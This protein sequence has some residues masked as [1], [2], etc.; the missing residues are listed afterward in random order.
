MNA[1]GKDQRDLFTA[2]EVVKW[3]ERFLQK[4]GYEL[5]ATCNRIQPKP[6]FHGKRQTENTHYEIM[7]TACQNIQDA[8]NGL[9]K[10]K[11]VKAITTT[12]AD[13]VLAFPPLSEYSMIDFLT[14]KRGRSYSDIK[15]E[16]FMVWL[17]NPE[18]ETTTCLVGGPQDALLNQHF[19]K[20]GMMSF[21]A[22]IAMRLSHVLL[23][24]EEEPEN[25]L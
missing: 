2:E 19:V 18:R 16:R 6:D 23:T 17:C 8:P 1:S 21:D 7:G 12:E 24:D 25:L 13:Y 11:A 15:Q 5:Q 20:M 10:L 3:L 22:F 9:A 14:S 4:A